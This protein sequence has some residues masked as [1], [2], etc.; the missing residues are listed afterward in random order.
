[1]IGQAFLFNAV[2][3]SYGLVLTR[4]HNVPEGRAG[5]YLVP[6]AASNFLGPV[7]LGPLFDTVGRRT[8]ICGTYAVAGMLLIA[9][10]LGFGSDAFSAWTQTLAWMSIFFF[11]SAAG[12]SAYL[13]ASE[14]FPLETRALAIAIFYALGT[15]IGG[16]AAPSLFG[17]LIETGS[18]W[19][20]AGGYMFAAALMLIAALAEAFLGID[21]EGRPL[22]NI[23]GP[24]STS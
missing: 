8:M 2:F 13:T 22:E 11:G 17:Y 1:M 12:S 7:L 10:A 18:Q 19:A 4:F 3:F 6:L 24:L 21:A 20:L 14:I 23:A 15:A 5:I 16:T 9:T